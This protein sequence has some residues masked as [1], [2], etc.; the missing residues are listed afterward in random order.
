MSDEVKV[1]MKRCNQCGEEKPLE[2][3]F[4]KNKRKEG[5]YFNRCKKCYQEASKKWR[6]NNKEKAKEIS[7]KWYEANKERQRASANR[8]RS[9]NKERANEISRQW[10][11]KNKELIKNRRMHNE[12]V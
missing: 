11:G 10:Y 2:S 3:G 6:E 8:W 9:N 5:S 1:I 7:K 4:Y 12:N